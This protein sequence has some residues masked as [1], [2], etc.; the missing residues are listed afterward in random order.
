MGSVEHYFNQ[1]KV[2]NKQLRY[3]ENT[4]NCSRRQLLRNSIVLFQE[5]MFHSFSEKFQNKM[6]DDRVKCVCLPHM[7]ESKCTGLGLSPDI[8]AK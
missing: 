5:Q 7:V 6:L 4:F 1:E 3:L 8:T 2:H